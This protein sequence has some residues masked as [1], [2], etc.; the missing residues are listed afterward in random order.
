LTGDNVSM[1]NRPRWPV[2]AV[3]TVA[4]VVVAALI[5][6]NL[7]PASAPTLVAR[8]LPRAAVVFDTTGTVTGPAPAIP[9]AR[10]GGTIVVLRTSPVSLSAAARV[11]ADRSALSLLFRTLTGYRRTPAGLELVGDLATNTGQ[12]SSDGLTWTYHLRSGV[13]FADG[14]AVTSAEVVRGL[15]PALHGLLTP[16]GLRSIDAT[17]VEITLARPMPQ[18]PLLLALPD[19]APASSGPIPLASGPYRPTTPSTWSR[20]PAWDPVTDPIRHAYPDTI[21]F[22]VAT[23]DQIAARVAASSPDAALVAEDVG[24][25]VAPAARRVVGPTGVGVYVLINTE[26]VTDP[27]VRRSLNYA[28][29]RGAAADSIVDTTFVPMTTILPAL[30]RGPHVYDAYPAG[31]HGNLDKARRLLAGRF[32][33][34]LTLCRDTDSTAFD[35]AD[36]VRRSF[37]RAGFTLTLSRLALADYHPG[38]TVC[39]LI[40]LRFDPR[41]PDG[42][43][44]LGTLVGGYSAAGTL[45]DRLAALAADPD[46]S[47][48]APGYVALDEAAMRDV[49][50]AVPV[51][52]Q[53][54]QAVIGPG[55]LTAQIDPVAGRLDLDAL[56][57]ASA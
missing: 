12:V 56:S 7:L 38:T 40:L 9:G 49:A 3:A 39:D 30:L 46:R 42:D 17:T 51:L 19:S 31:A 6:Y 53:T 47:A 43:A 32:I 35:L 34:D 29:D 4:L 27:N 18:L 36:V 24:P 55:V 50:P 25:S 52:E 23:R 5:V 48:A 13:R 15:D 2:A 20:N 41:F 45:T 26:R 16:P 33:P 11:D 57:V 1:D 14:S 21:E 54:A 37:E 8:P 28:I 22:E 44:V 10:R